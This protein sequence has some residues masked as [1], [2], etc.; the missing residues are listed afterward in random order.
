[1][2]RD[3]LVRI[4]KN[5]LQRYDFVDFALLFG[6]WAEGEPSP[7]SDVD[8]GIYTNRDITLQELGECA[9]QLEKSIR[10][11]VDVVLLN[12]LFKFKPYFAFRIIKSG[13]LLVCRNQDRYVEFK[14]QA[15]LNYLDVQPLKDS[16]D[17]AFRKR[18][19]QGEFGVIPHAGTSADP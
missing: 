15:I 1:M 19:D 13:F 2:E 14:R 5:T 12:D 7:L 9:A 18:L 17:R 8:V 11:G 10:R 3:E 6:S 16:V 4:L